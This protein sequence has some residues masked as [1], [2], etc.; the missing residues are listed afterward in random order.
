MRKPKDLRQG[1]WISPM[2]WI[3]S[4]ESPFVTTISADCLTPREARSLAK[5]L[6]RFAEWAEA[7]DPGLKR[8]KK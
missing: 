8:K 2:A 3:D 7:T 4:E 5:W 6:L 1:G